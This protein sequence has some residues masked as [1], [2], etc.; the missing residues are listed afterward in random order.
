M[1]LKYGCAGA[2]FSLLAAISAT[3]VSLRPT[4]SGLSCA[5][6]SWAHAGRLPSSALTV[7]TQTPLN[8][9]LVVPTIPKVKLL[10]GSG[11]WKIMVRARGDCV[12]DFPRLSDCLEWIERNCSHISA[13]VLPGHAAAWPNSC[14]W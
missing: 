1:T 6:R 2:L 14:Q 4:P 9:R 12:C 11:Y 3:G 10:I 13:A 7:S 5:I 8:G